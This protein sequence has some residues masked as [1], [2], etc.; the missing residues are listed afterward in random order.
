MAQMLRFRGSHSQAAPCRPQ[1]HP[2]EI[3]T[4]NPEVVAGFGT[5]L[6]SHDVD[7]GVPLFLARWHVHQT[8]WSANIFDVIRNRCLLFPQK[9]LGLVLLERD[10]LLLALF[11]GLLGRHQ[12]LLIGSTFLLILRGSRA[13]LGLLRFLLHTR[14][15]TAQMARRHPKYPLD[16]FDIMNRSAC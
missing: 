11:G 3:R 9:A 6:I 7:P 8:P 10:P 13:V 15:K 1:L 4:R 2:I 12:E 14:Q 5:M 16:P